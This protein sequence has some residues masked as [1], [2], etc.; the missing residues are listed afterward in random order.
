MSKFRALLV[1]IFVT[2]VAYT[3]VVIA[4]HGINLL[5]LF[6][7]DMTEMAWP[8]QFN[9]DFLCFLVLSA[10]WVAWRHHFSRAGFALSV[11]ALFGG[12]LF[13]SVYLF[14]Q[15]FRVNGNLTTLLVGSR[16]ADSA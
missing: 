14:I 2:L 4:N 12:A 10:L 11:L 1:I 6:F 3:S 13:L 5:P 15:S 7:G 16:T 8:G 9:L